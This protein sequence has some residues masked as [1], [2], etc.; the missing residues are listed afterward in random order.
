MTSKSDRLIERLLKENGVGIL[1][2]VF[3]INDTCCEVRY[4]LRISNNS[5]DLVKAIIFIVENGR[6]TNTW[7]MMSDFHFIVPEFRYIP[8]QV[9]NEYFIR[10]GSDYANTVSQND[11][12]I[13]SMI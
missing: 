10:I 11:W 12:K 3:Y 1:L 7:Q 8:Q 13:L 6:T 9:I 2:E 5:Y 4:F